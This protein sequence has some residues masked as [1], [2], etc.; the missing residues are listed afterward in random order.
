MMKHFRRLLAG[1]LCALMLMPALPVC[2]EEAA[3]VSFPT[4]MEAF[5]ARSAAYF[6]E[7]EIE[8]A[9][10]S[11]DVAARLAPEDALPWAYR[12][13]IYYALGRYAEAL[14]A[15]EEAL[16]RNP[17]LAEGWAIQAMCHAV[18][19]DIDAVDTALLY[20][21]VCGG[22][23]NDEATLALAMA[24]EANGQQQRAAEAF[25]ALDLAAFTE[26]QREAYKRALLRTGNAEKAQALGLIAPGQRN[27]ALDAA[28]AAGK[29]TLQEVEIPGL[30]EGAAPVAISPDGGT[31]L[32]RDEE[33]GLCVL[34]G[35][36]VTPLAY[37]PERGAPVVG[38]DVE[39]YM[40]FLAQRLPTEDGTV[41]SRDG[42]YAV[43]TTSYITMTQMR[44]FNLMLLDTHTGDVFPVTS[45]G[46]KMTQEGS[47]GVIHARFDQS[48]RYLYYT[49]FGGLGE[50]RYSLLRYDLLTGENEMCC[51]TAV[52]FYRPNLWELPDGRWISALDTFVSSEGS[53]LNVYTPQEDGTW[54][55]LPRKL[56]VPAG[57][58]NLAQRDDL[59]VPGAEMS[60]RYAY[61]KALLYSASSGY[62]LMPLVERM[63]QAIDI[64]MYLSRIQ[65][66]QDFSGMDTYWALRSLDSTHMEP[67]TEQDM[68]DGFDRILAAAGERPSRFLNLQYILNVQLSPDGQYAL[69]CAGE[70]V[71]FAFLLL[72][73]ED[74][75]LCRIDAPEGLAGTWLANQKALSAPCLFWCEDGRL[76]IQRE[77]GSVGAY[78]LE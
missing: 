50:E 69:L 37:N 1:V 2:A 53:G 8:K 5:V 56:T 78:T 58:T 36:Q 33:I 40:T 65:P 15:A 76:L 4:D 19:N 31:V 71:E 45:M 63:S 67:I 64:P 55:N 21:E 24:W 62:A 12:G 51:N 3:G 38:N 42:R 54:V 22:A 9:L 26:E 10:A 47:G 13:N 25:A 23:L 60:I 32:L 57:W 74:M 18:L 46:S 11:L 49:A 43:M 17:A 30:P 28:F 73:L 34:R 35:G 16:R 70:G 6:R 52:G 44:W 59:L 41:W 20:L 66:E 29:L 61:P 68:L 72:R 7:G 27:A 48:G 39:R 14:E 75:A 77:D